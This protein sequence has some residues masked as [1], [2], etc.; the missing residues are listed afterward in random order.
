VKKAAAPYRGT[1]SQ[2]VAERAGVSRSTVSLVMS[3]KARGRV[4]PEV[5][6]TVLLAARELGY[7]PNAAAR[8]LRL[9]RT[10]SIALVVANVANPFFASVLRGAEHAARKQ[11]YAVMLLDTMNDPDWLQWVPD[12]L[13]ARALDG[14]ILYIGD[15]ISE[16]EAQAFGRN[17]VL[18]EAESPSAS[19]I[20]LDV[21]QAATQA[22]E[23]LI[24]LGHTRI[25]YLAADY[26]KETFRLRFAAYEQALLKAGIAPNTQWTGRATFDVETATATA[27]RLLRQPDTPT[28]IVCDDDLL[29]AA[30][31]KSAAIL[32][33]HVPRDLSIVGFDDI[34][35]ARL[36]QPEL[37]TVAIPAE[38]IGKTSIRLM[39]KLLSGQGPS[40]QHVP[41]RLMVRGSTALPR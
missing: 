41:L 14:C 9:G 25:G 35:L 37:T 2:E 7:H 18:I 1:T 11:R 5:Q 29:A 21:Y 13:A 10:F 36:L 38:E 31:Y 26:A 8:S 39:Q 27:T 33:L 19:S 6:E 3:G 30:V 23:H 20:L 4:S 22:T 17:I 40:T 16:A 32:G 24:A 15:P 28:A 34:E 12:V